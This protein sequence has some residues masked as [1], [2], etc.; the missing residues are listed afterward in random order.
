[1]SKPKKKAMPEV[2]T[3]G[4]INVLTGLGDVAKDKRENA[5][6]QL[7]LMN[8]DALAL[9]YRTQAM[10]ARVVN[11]PPDNMFREGFEPTVKDDEEAEEELSERCEELCVEE[12]IVTALKWKRAYGGA[13]ILIG[14]NDGK[15]DL[16]QPLN[17]E[18]IKSVDFL[19]VFD[20][21]EAM[22]IEWEINPLKKGFAEPT[23]F[24]LNPHILGNGISPL[25]RVHA[26]RFLVFQGELVN[27]RQLT[28]SAQGVARGWADSVYQRIAR[29][30]RDY[31]QTWAGINS[32][33]ADFSQS[34]YKIKGLAAA[35][36]SDK[37]KTIKRRFQ[38]INAGRSIIQATIL[39]AENEEFERK[40]TALSGVADVQRENMNHVAAEAGIPTTVLFG[41]SPGG[42]NA[43]GESDLNIWYDMVRAMQRKEATPPLKR[44]LKLILLS[45]EGPT[46]GKLPD[47][48]GVKFPSLQQQ[49]P[50]EQAETR[51]I[52]AQTDQLYLNMG[53]A[54]AEDIVNSH[55]SG[56]EFNPELDVDLDALEERE[57]VAGEMREVE[58]EATKANF[59]E[60]GQ[61]TPPKPVAGPPKSKPGA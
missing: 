53:A 58:A 59:E 34:V 54:S 31:D 55:F 51:Q 20:A 4:F 50:K 8:Y 12:K 27:R 25:Q 35:L 14:A 7:D 36:L 24:E 57:A 47:K 41:I 17:E 37:D 60:H 44:L 21:K 39:D 3:D 16:S 15:A 43:T 49:N 52:I 42:L 5:T 38:M 56:K 29:G 33:M 11:L 18:N 1:M 45:K 19:T 26:S 6:L 61:P 13:V 9:L 10:A 48:F 22:P 46:S 28:E 2:T 30:I 32:L 40:T 23:M